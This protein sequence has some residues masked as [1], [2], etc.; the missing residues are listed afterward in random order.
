V[1]PE[2]LD[3]GEESSVVLPDQPTQQLTYGGGSCGVVVESALGAHPSGSRWVP[4]EVQRH[5]A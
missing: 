3:V 2:K 5:G 1:G 4:V